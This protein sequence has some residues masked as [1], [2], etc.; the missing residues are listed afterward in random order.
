MATVG[1]GLE[2]AN[3]VGYATGSTTSGNKIMGA[4]FS[5]VSGEAI[6]L[7]TIK[8]V[9]YD[10]EEGLQQLSILS[11]Q[12]WAKYNEIDTETGLLIDFAKFKTYIDSVASSNEA[13]N[14]L[15]YVHGADEVCDIYEC[16]SIWC[17]YLAWLD[18]A[19]IKIDF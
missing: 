7:N 6:D 4:Q 17:A 12:I 15:F 18:M 11:A 19:G 2:S 10:L 1:F 13:V 3:I 8:V 5:A 14:A 16:S 9:G